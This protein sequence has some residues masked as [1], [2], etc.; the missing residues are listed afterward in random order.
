VLGSIV[1][2]ASGLDVQCLRSGCSF[3]CRST[4]A[5]LPDGD[6]MVSLAVP[7]Y[8]TQTVQIHIANPTNCGCC[9]CCPFAASQDVVLQ[10][11]GSPITGC[12]SDLITDPL[13]CGAC[14]KTCSTDAWC[15]NKT[16]TPVYSPC[17]TSSDAAASCNDYCA[18]HGKTC[19]AACG[20]SGTESIHWWGQGS[21]NC[22]DNIYSSSGTC[23]QSLA[24][25]S[26]VRCCCAG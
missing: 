14:G 18:K 4:Q 21:V 11:D 13:N 26:G 10:P 22:G 12:C 1:A 5:R 8:H 16:C 2:Q 25:Y 9:G 6:Y 17:V 3:F 7:G 15:A 24:G 19:A 20:P 23:A